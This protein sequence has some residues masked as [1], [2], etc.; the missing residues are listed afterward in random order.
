MEINLMKNYPRTK[1][2][3]SERAS[4][5]T[6][7]DRLI[8]RKFDFEFFD[9]DRKN[10]Y[11]GFNYNPRFW[12]PVVPD[13]VDHY[14]LKKDNYVLDIGC[15]KGFMLYDMM[16]IVSG[17]KVRGVDISKYAID[18]CMDQ[19]KDYLSVGNAMDLPFEDNEFN[20]VISITTIHN[21]LYDECILALKEI[22]RVSKGKSF[23][24]VD[25]YGNDEEKK[26]MLDWNLTA[27]TILHEDEW[28]EL[29]DK[30][31]Y[32]VDYFWFKP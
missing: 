15:A 14:D 27:K 2:D 9:G 25:A 4:L 28:R 26:M 8:A 23:I 18:N 7:E 17:I 29:F 30:A 24:T 3:T 31:G 6:E 5:K 12:Q 21:L 16:N 11:G 32:K 13:F 10:G 1:R 20:L 22:E 19:V